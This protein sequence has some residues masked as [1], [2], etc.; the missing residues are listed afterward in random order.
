LAAR[1]PS[2]PS[3]GLCD[4]SR[5]SLLN[6]QP[7]QPR[8]SCFSPDHRSTHTFLAQARAPS[9]HSGT[10]LAA[11]LLC[12]ISHSS[13]SHT[14]TLHTGSITGARL[15][16]RTL[17]IRHEPPLVRAHRLTRA[18][19]K[20]LPTTTPPPRSTAPVPQ[21]PVPFPTTRFAH[22]FAP[23]RSA[24]LPGGQAVRTKQPGPPI[25]V[26]LRACRPSVSARPARPASEWEDHQRSALVVLGVVS[27]C[28]GQ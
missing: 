7:H 11:R 15:A 3:L 16:H 2:S 22:P 23:C 18:S 1:T 14:S 25:C 19:T 9:R 20:A 5:S 27:S 13:T 26:H 17:L 21:T 24:T 4:P 10:V 8:P 6:T 28:I 12:D